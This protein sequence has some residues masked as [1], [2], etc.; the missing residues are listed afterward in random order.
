MTRPGRRGGG[1]NKKGLVSM[2]EKKKPGRP[3]LAEGEPCSVDE[4]GKE[5]GEKRLL[6]PAL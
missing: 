6:A 5:G 4:G 1:K 3:C 2:P